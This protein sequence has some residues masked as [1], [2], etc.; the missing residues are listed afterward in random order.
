MR[1]IKSSYL[2]ENEMKR[3]MK[4]VGSILMAAV[5]V[6][7]LFTAWP[8]TALA[9]P[10]VSGATVNISDVDSV[11]S[12]SLVIEDLLNGN[13]FSNQN[14]GMD[15]YDTVTVKGSKMNANESLFINIPKGAKVVWQAN[16]TDVDGIGFPEFYSTLVYIN[17][18]GSTFELPAGGTLWAAQSYGNV[19][20]G[21]FRVYYV[22]ISASM[23]PLAEHRNH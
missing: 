16:Y 18:A 17:G 14:A 6:M 1:G 19:I 3:I 9:V 23:R 13:N 7:A 2:E 20:S 4:R 11:A 12:I 15:K 22:G 8:V 5:M 21:G 10:S